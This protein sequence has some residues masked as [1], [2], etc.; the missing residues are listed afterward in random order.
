MAERKPLANC[1][2]HLAK[3]GIGARGSG[4][5]VGV[6]CANSV[7]GRA[8]HGTERVAKR[9]SR[10][11]ALAQS[12]CWG[13]QDSPRLLARS[14]TRQQY[15][16]LSK[17]CQA[18]SCGEMHSLP[19]SFSLVTPSCRQRSR[20]GSR[21]SGRISAIGKSNQ[22]ARWTQADTENGLGF[23]L[24]ARRGV[25]ARQIHLLERPTRRSVAGPSQGS[26]VRDQSCRSLA[27]L[28]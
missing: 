26:I 27:A 20:R 3:A 22:S 10:N 5:K 4:Q 25:L 15:W 12:L 17:L 6:Y 11:H 7:P 13:R 28:L 21:L 18:E 2:S 16:S 9:P 14:L 1:S 8:T 19:T 23:W 24:H